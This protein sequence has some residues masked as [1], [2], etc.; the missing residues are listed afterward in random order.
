MS[1]GPLPADQLDQ[2]AL[3]AALAG[4]MAALEVVASTGSTNADLLAAARGG[5]PDRSVLVA[6]RQDRGRGRLDR[7]WVS[8]PGSGL[9]FS[10]LLRPGAVPP[11]RLGWLPL[12]AGLA[13]VRGIGDLRDVEVALKWPNDVLLGPEQAKGAG[14]LAE[15]EPGASGGPAVVVGIGINVGARIEELPEGGTSLAAEGAAVDRTELLSAVLRRLLTDE[16]EW[17]ATGGDPDAT[18]LRE[19]YRRH[20]ATLGREV[21]VALPG[22]SDLVGRASDLDDDGRLV[23]REPSGAVRTVAAGDVVHLRALPAS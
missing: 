3:R 21:R 23:L 7:Q 1:S 11:R 19:A 13:V 16:A 4:R 15:A 17:R 22:G 18:G 8:A 2:E 12:L 14:I 20:C 9:T 6:E 10:V 5:A